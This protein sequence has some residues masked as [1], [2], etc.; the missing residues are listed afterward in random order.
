MVLA[1]SVSR[2]RWLFSHVTCAVLGT[3]ALLL[4]AGL[5]TGLGYALVSGEGGKVGPIVGAA[6]AQVPATLALAGFVVLA[7]VAVPRWASALAWAALAFCLV[8][9]QIGELLELPQAV[10]DLSPF[11]HA[12][13]APAEDVTAGPLVVLGAVALAFTAVSVALFRRRDL[14]A[15]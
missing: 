6:L 7:V 1:G 5:T 3:G 13:T 15:Q 8:L 9:G 14:T 10:M 4:L 11:T 2:S 12:P